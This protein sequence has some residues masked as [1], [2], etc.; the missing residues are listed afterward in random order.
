MTTTP[1]AHKNSTAPQSTPLPDL[2]EPLQQALSQYGPAIASL[3]SRL[4]AQLQPLCNDLMVYRF[5]KGHKFDEKVAYEKLLSSLQWRHDN[6]ILQ[7]R[8][9]AVHLP[10]R[11]FPHARKIMRVYPHNILHG[12]D[13]RGQPVSIERL[14]FTNPH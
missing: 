6:K 9:K 1:K 2:F 7:I 12:V 14:G 11:E 8:S 13:K 4:P 3:Q 10:Q 5:L